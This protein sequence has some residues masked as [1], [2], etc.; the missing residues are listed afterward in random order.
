MN[1]IGI[2]REGPG[3]PT[4]C[5]CI[6]L[7]LTTL[8]AAGLPFSLL[9]LLCPSFL[10]PMPPFLSKRPAVDGSVVVASISFL[11]FVMTMISNCGEIS[12]AELN[13]GATT[14]LLLKLC[15]SAGQLT[16]NPKPLK[17]SDERRRS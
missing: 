2:D 16:L 9:L 8:G 6:Q 1:S 7:L 11:F 4:D 12:T 10:E 13:R 15:S 3:T 17:P 14:Q 5:S